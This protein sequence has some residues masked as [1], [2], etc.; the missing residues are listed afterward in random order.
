MND[1]ARGQQRLLI[2]DDSKVVRVTARKILRDH[3]ETVEAVDGEKAWDILTSEAPF[4]LVISDL[5]MPNLDGFGL[6]ERIRQSHLTHLRDLPVIIITG[7]NDSEASKERATQAGATDFIG[8]PFD[9]IHLLARTQAHASAHST[10]RMLREETLALED[11]SALDPLTR[12]ANEMAFMERGYQQLAYAVRHN[13]RLAVCSIEVDHFGALFRA[14]GDSVTE[15]IIQTVATVLT[16]AI[17]HEDTA[18][19]IG[20]ARFALLLPGLNNIGI[21][22]LANR[23]RKSI[24]QR[25][26][27]HKDMRIH[28]TISVG[29]A[30]TEIRRDTRFDELL[31][32]ANKRLVYALA[33]GGDQVVYEDEVSPAPPGHPELVMAT[34][35]RA[36]FMIE[37]AA[38]LADNSIEVEEIEVGL[39]NMANFID[40]L[41]GNK[42]AAIECRMTGTAASLPGKDMAAGSLAA[43]AA[44]AGAEQDTPAPLNIP[45]LSLDPVIPVPAA[46]LSLPWEQADAE[47]IEITAGINP[48]TA[49]GHHT[50]RYSM[51]A[52]ATD[53]ATGQPA[54]ENIENADSDNPSIQ[55][56]DI[57]TVRIGLLERLL[58]GIQSLFMRSRKPE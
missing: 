1:T 12:I 29:V 35:D 56:V 49:V 44:S 16:A 11:E 37:M 21:Q 22:N 41:P 18:A 26:L 8:K 39:P 10:T 48:Y 36:E 47:L 34:A 43:N 28:Y 19:R 4:S 38:Q 5:S 57:R 25:V 40:A 13:T 3:F 45:D 7:S 2:V 14:Y 46:G 42:L 15:S 17:R 23:I 20:A 58:T 30:A 33:H 31:S 24:K 53:T 52:G 54:K 6:L 50:P 9:A 27:K 51:A 32:V 55:T